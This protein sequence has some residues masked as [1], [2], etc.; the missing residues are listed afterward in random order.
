[1]VVDATVDAFHAKFKALY[2]GGD[3]SLYY[4]VAG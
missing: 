2:A 1:V 3:I 4:G